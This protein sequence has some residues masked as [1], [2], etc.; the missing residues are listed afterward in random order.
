MDTKTEA[1]GQALPF[2]PLAN[3]F[4][5]LE[6]K[7]FDE[8]AGDIQRRGLTFPIVTFQGQI[9]DGRNRQ[10]ACEKAGVEPRYVEFGGPAE[11]ILRFIISANIHRRHLKPEDRRK[12]I[13]ELLLADPTKSDRSLGTELKVDKNTIAAVRKAAEST[14]EISPVAKR[15]GKDGKA[16][17]APTKKTTRP[18][19]RLVEP[20]PEV[21]TSAPPQPPSAVAETPKEIAHRQVMAFLA[22]RLEQA[23]LKKLLQLMDGHHVVLCPKDITVLAGGDQQQGN[24]VDAEASAN[25]RKEQLAELAAAGT[26]GKLVH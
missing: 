16:R 24:D 6:G 19:L 14:G 5:L 25:K 4:P 23:D 15:T 26:Q 17:T 18:K 1:K 22:I 13:K 7:E 12:L 9:I 20:E 2:H 11:D 10:R 8:L 21:P 3:K